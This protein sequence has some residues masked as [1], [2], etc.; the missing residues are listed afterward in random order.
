MTASDVAG[1]ASWSATGLP[2]GLT[3]NATT[4]VIT[5]TP[6]ASGS[7]SV[8]ITVVDS[9]GY[10]TS[11]PYL[12]QINALPKIIGPADLTDWTINRDYPDTADQREPGN[13]SVHVVGDRPASGPFDHGRR[14]RLRH[15]DDDRNLHPDDTSHRRVRRKR[16][17]GLH[18]Q[19]QCD[20]VDHRAVVIG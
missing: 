18:A 15:T 4:G 14:C 13:G 20:P 9:L 5:G 12:L 10:T 19:D 6:T 16:H 3:I 11:R 7:S 1:S 8:Q 17:A 2:A